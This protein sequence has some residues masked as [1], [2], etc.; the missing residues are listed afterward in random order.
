MKRFCKL[1]VLLLIDR[2]ITDD[3][4][5]SNLRTAIANELETSISAENRGIDEAIKFVR[6]RCDTYIEE[7]GIWDPS[8][9]VVEF[10]GDGEEYVAELEEIMEGLETLKF[11]AKIEG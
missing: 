4:E 8:T 6:N 2:F 7:H 5:R 9:G 3:T 10:R 1:N 11:K